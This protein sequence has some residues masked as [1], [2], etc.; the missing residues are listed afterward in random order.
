MTYQAIV[1]FQQK[2]DDLEYVYFAL[3]AIFVILM[4]VYLALVSEDC[5]NA[6]QGRQ[7]VRFN[8]KKNVKNFNLNILF[9][10]VVCP[11]TV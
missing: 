4:L 8:I 6:V 5:N 2:N 1:S 10:F 9:Y 11:A 3:N 7:E